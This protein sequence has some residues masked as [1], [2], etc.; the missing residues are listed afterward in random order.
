MPRSSGSQVR[1]GLGLARTHGAGAAKG[2]DRDTGK[3]PARAQAKTHADARRVL[4]ARAARETRARP[5]GAQGGTSG[6]HP[7]RTA[8]QRPTM[9]SGCVRSSWLAVTLSTTNADPSG[10]TRK[11]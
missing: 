10:R 1:E 6:S 4:R 11:L 2:A 7:R 8:T 9:R 3:G 5:V